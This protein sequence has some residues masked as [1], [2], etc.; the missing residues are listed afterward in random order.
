MAEERRRLGRGLAAL[1]G[2]MA[3]PEATRAG[4]GRA[5]QVVIAQVLGYMISKFL[6]IRFISG[7]EAPGKRIYYI[8]LFIGIA[9]VSL[10]LFA[11]IPA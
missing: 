2:D 4:L 8:L 9:W 6:G 11:I 7:M 10:L 5:A 3:E 1:L